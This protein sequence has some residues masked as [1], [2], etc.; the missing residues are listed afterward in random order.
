[1]MDQMAHAL[2]IDPVAFHLK[3]V[4]RAYLDETPYTSWALPECIE[5]GAEIFGW[6]AGWRRAGGGGGPGRRGG[7]RGTGA[8]RARPP[9]RRAAR[10]R[11]AP[12]RAAP[13]RRSEVRR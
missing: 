7:G 12:R 9:R 1:M 6:S 13:R 8:G 3:N 5:R 11:A 10:R 2:E 4:S